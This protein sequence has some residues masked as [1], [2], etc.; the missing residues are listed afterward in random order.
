[1]NVVHI[2]GRLG[3][4]PDTFSAGCKFSVATNRKSK[5]E[6]VTDWHRVTVF[7]KQADFAAKYFKK[8]SLVIVT[9]EIHYS[10]YE[11]DGHQMRGV[12]IV[13]SERGGHVSF[14]PSSKR[15]NDTTGN[16]PPMPG[17]YEPPADNVPF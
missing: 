10:T 11:K 5:G 7:G 13:V 14:G 17:S 4:D 6:E 2:M 1:M 8:G 16:R 9:G 3:G 12:D 15:D